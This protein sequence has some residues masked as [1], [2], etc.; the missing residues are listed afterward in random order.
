MRLWTFCLSDYAIVNLFW[1]LESK[2]Y[3]EYDVLRFT[4]IRYD[5][6]KNQSVKTSVTT[7]ANGSGRTVREVRGIFFFGVGR[8]G[9]YGVPRTVPYCSVKTPYRG[10]TSKDQAGL[11]NKSCG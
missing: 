3:N 4:F 10:N 7:G 8:F 6:R 2:F 9:E 11:E 1:R 5:R